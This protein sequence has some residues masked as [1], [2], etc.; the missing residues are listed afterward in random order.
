M[1]DVQLLKFCR[2]R[3]FD[4][5]KIIEMFKNYMEYRH[6]NDIDNI[7]TNFEFTMKNDVNA[8]YPRGYCGVDKLGRPVYIER[9]GMIKPSKIWDLGVSEELLMKSYM[10]S[11][12]V[13]I[14]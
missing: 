14:K 1:N 13:L 6:D 5:E 3:N 9:S 8:H 7:C 12:E 2:A 10:Q 11:Y 4:I